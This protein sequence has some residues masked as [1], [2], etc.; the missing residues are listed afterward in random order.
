MMKQF[1]N[2]DSSMQE[3]F[4]PVN[5]AKERQEEGKGS[6]EEEEWEAGERRWEWWE[7]EGVRRDGRAGSTNHTS[8]KEER[9]GRWGC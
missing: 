5:G 1:T 3:E 9:E 7:E 8:S 4:N 6:W 2:T